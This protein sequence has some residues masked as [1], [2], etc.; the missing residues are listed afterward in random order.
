MKRR[1][2]L[3]TIPLLLLPAAML[4]A[5]N[6]S[7]LW[8]GAI[9]TPNADLGVV[10]NVHQDGDKWAAE[11][12]IPM[13]NVSAL[14]LADFKVEGGG[15][16]FGLP[17]PGDPRY[18]GKLA[19]DGKTI[20][21]NFTQGGESM[22]LEL[23]WKSEPRAVVKAPANSGDVQVLEG[24]WEGA[25]DANGT[26]LRLRFNFVKNADGSITGTIDSLD[27]GA[28]GIPITTI[29]RT[30][31]SIKMEVPAVT[32]SYEGTLSKDA[33]AITGTWS[34]GGGTLPLKVERKKAEVTR[35]PAA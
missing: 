6:P 2:A 8:E 21:G 17:G 29:A 31:D 28:N 23:K 7:G 26:Q 32:G 12:D 1:I 27:Q 11:I 5:A 34:Q 25:L 9:K 30:G 20:S 14:P 13:Q 24:V 4:A 33:S 35:K 16:S 10:V 22:A 18:S 15:I 3:F 19:A